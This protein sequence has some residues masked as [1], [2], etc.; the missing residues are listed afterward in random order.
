MK[1]WW[2]G[3]RG[4]PGKWHMASRRGSLVHQLLPLKLCINCCNQ[5]RRAPTSDSRQHCTSNNVT[6]HSHPPPTLCRNTEDNSL[7]VTWSPLEGLNAIWSSS[8]L[9]LLIRQR[10]NTQDTM[11][12]MFPSMPVVLH[13]VCLHFPHTWITFSCVWGCVCPPWPAPAMNKQPTASALG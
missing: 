4:L 12:E 5:G 13:F 9:F 8:I 6:S 3:V 7:L 11:L 2:G 1:Y 10:G